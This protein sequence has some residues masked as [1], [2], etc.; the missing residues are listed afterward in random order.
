M[1]ISRSAATVSMTLLIVGAVYWIQSPHPV[2]PGR[3]PEAVEGSMVKH[4]VARTL[5]QQTAAK[6]KPGKAAPGSAHVNEAT[7]SQTWKQ[8]ATPSNAGSP[9]PEQS[10]AKSAGKRPGRASGI[11]DEEAESGSAVVDEPVGIRLAS[12]VRLPA[13]ALPVDFKMS[14][15][16]EKMLKE[17]VDDYYR[18][19]AG[20]VESA[21]EGDGARSGDEGPTVL[22]S[23]GPNVDAARKRAD[24]R[25]RALFG[26]AAYNRMTM[27]SVLESHLP[28]ARP[29]ATDAAGGE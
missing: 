2:E 22:V 12:D 29:P 25:F 23:N 13:A 6:L 21:P 17:I 10:M 18:E 7:P 24:Y 3:S 9:V 11:S 8:R 4:Q 28:L 20:T 5:L 26:N 14:P 15:A 19:L 16:A 27:N 1:N